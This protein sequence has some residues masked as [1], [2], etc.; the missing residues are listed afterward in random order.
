MILPGQAIISREILR[1]TISSTVQSQ[2]CGVDLTL[3][4]I[5]TW[6]SHGTVDFDNSSRRIAPTVEIP[7]RSVGAVR[8]GVPAPGSEELSQPTT[9][10]DTVNGQ[11][12]LAHGSYLVEFNETV[13]VPLDAMGQIFVRSSLFRSGVH[14]TAG[15]VD[16]G[17]H[18]ALG[19]LLNVVNPAGLELHRNARLA[20]LVLHQLAE[21][22]AGYNGIYQGSQSMQ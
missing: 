16:S 8:G 5:M 2:P 3:K 17:Y 12:H 9:K 13:S 1:G 18:G 7:F 11:I 10:D 4:K 20:Q 22:V 19:A 6:T 14:L 15:V 21:P